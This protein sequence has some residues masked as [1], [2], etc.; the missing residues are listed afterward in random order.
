MDYYQYLLN[1]AVFYLTISYI[2]FFLKETKSGWNSSSKYILYAAMALT[3]TFTGLLI[4]FTIML[5]YIVFSV[6]ILVTCLPFLRI[7]LKKWLTTNGV[8]VSFFLSE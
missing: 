2:T 3:F 6:I 1:L 7:L 5:G 8:I 4:G